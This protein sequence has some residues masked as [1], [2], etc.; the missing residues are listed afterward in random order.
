M[1]VRQSDRRSQPN[2]RKR[3]AH[4]SRCLRQVRAPGGP[5]SRTSPSLSRHATNIVRIRATGVTRS[6][7][8]FAPAGV[9]R[10]IPVRAR[11]PKRK[12]LGNELAGEVEAVG[13]AVTEFEV[14]DRVFGA[15]PYLALSRGAHAEY[16]C[17]PERFRSRT[18]PPG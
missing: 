8:T 11:R 2:D 18:Y 7:H 17:V 15:L 13:A 5:R 1:E 6:T 12:I 3:E 10:A 9:R 4:E 16:M 14:G